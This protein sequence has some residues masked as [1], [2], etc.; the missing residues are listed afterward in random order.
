MKLMS[1]Q[2]RT[3]D[4]LQAQSRKNLKILQSLLDYFEYVGIRYAGHSLTD[5]VSYKYQI[6]QQ[7]RNNNIKGARLSLARFKQDQA[8]LT[9]YQ[10]SV[11]LTRK[12]N[13]EAFWQKLALAIPI[14]KDSTLKQLESRWRSH[15]DYAH[16]SSEGLYQLA[17]FV[18][19]KLERY[20]LLALTELQQN[21]DQV[22]TDVYQSFTTYLS[23]LKAYLKAEKARL[24]NAM[25]RRLQV[26]ARRCD[27]T[28]D[29]MVT[30]M[31][32][33]VKRLAGLDDYKIHP[34]QTK[35][36]ADHFEYFNS[37]LASK[38]NKYTRR[39]L[40]KLPWYVASDQFRIHKTGQRI[41]IV[42]AKLVSRGKQFVG[43]RTLIRKIMPRTYFIED[44]LTKK[45]CFMIK[46][47]LLSN[48]DQNHV[49]D[50]DYVKLT[51]IKQYQ[52]LF[53][54]IGNEL[55]EI[56]ESLPKG[57]RRYLFRQQQAKLMAWQQ[58]LI[59]YQQ[60]IIAKQIHLLEAMLAKA[61]ALGSEGINY[62][63]AHKNEMDLLA[64]QVRDCYP[65]TY[66][67]E[68]AEHLAR[69]LDKLEASYRSLF[70]D[71][72]NNTIKLLL[73][74]L[75]Q[76]VIKGNNHLKP[77][78]E[79][80]E[81]L[82]KYNPAALNLFIQQCQPAM[83]VVY[84]K[85]SHTL[86]VISFDVT[87]IIDADLLRLIARCITLHKTFADK[88]LKTKLQHK[89]RLLYSK[90]LQNI[91]LS[92]ADEYNLTRMRQIEDCLLAVSDDALTELISKVGVSRFVS[93]S[94]FISQ[95]YEIYLSLINEC[96]ATET[97]S[98]VVR[99]RSKI[100]SKLKADFN[101]T[102]NE[103]KRVAEIINEVSADN[104]A[105]LNTCSLSAADRSLLKL[106]QPTHLF[107]EFFNLLLA[108]Q[109]VMLSMELMCN[110][111]CIIRQC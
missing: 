99:L 4:L 97:D 101:F 57:L 48:A 36:T 38:G 25:L 49:V 17:H 19:P 58:Q 33:A 2:G 14:E 104:N 11:E 89:L 100:Y 5:N 51:Y 20:Y 27:L 91:I 26:A 47:S 82:K 108:V 10:W 84:K 88:E 109:Q 73:T 98:L 41:L 64:N 9:H 53:D 111:N 29:D 1:Y 102:E 24:G 8:A 70:Y 81:G 15:R 23:R 7:I 6:R 74:E 34:P 93:R 21:R 22:P 94:Q 50:N 39:A 56:S 92:G 66:S 37:Y 12:F 72:E 107:H 55:L 79:F 67:R 40:Q 103:L 63:C 105:D 42:P 69:R 95:V 28:H 83:K 54:D 60:M 46:L 13:D 65:T 32:E 87:T 90:H 68:F 52:L 85:L 61:Y 43:L 80:L 62:L 59:E 86:K 3:S 71:P 45:Q 110:K 18:I 44:Y 77:L 16:V 35:M 75:Q 30:D 96:V 31:A 76:G 78:F 106:H